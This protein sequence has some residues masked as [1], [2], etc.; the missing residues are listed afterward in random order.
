MG[1]LER[2]RVR[3][4]QIGESRGFGDPEYVRAIDLLTRQERE[5]AHQHGLPY[6]RSIDLGAVWEPNEPDPRWWDTG[7]SAFLSLLPHFD[8]EDQ[9]RVEFEWI[10][11]D[12]VEFLS[13]SYRHSDHPLWQWGLRACMW[14]AEAVNGDR[15]R[16]ELRRLILNLGDGLFEVTA[17]D[18]NLA[19]ST[20]S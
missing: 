15:G 5:C 13:G 8:D 9:R 11:W 3:V 1:D 4:R 14:S 12:R 16:V 19:R 20:S 7:H 17:E 6:A 10:G 2:E 18:W